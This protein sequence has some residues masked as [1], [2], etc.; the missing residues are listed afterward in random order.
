M[1]KIELKRKKLDA[2]DRLIISLDVSSKSEVIRLCREIDNKV[3]I[4]KLG[5]ELIY[6][7]G[8]DI[9]S[10]VKS[11]GYGVLLDAKL[12]DIPNTVC[13]A[14][15]AIGKLGVE[16]ITI[17]TLGGSGMLKNAREKICKL[18]ISSGMFPPMLLGV[19]ILTSL[20]DMDLKNLGFK[21]GYKASVLNL[22]EVALNSNLDGIICSPNE[23]KL[24][25]K[26]YGSNFFIAT[27]GIRLSEDS[28]ADQKRFSTPDKAISDGADFIIVGRSITGKDNISEA[29]DV[30]LEKIKKVSKNDKSSGASQR[31]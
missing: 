20:D 31:S 9:I 11:F 12:H 4:L 19:T 26:T 25:R 8:L 17:H 1:G 6:S 14:A 18:S 29:I 15:A 23:V 28:P 7:A 22:V 13:K 27:P 16:M 5:L 10:T 30:F 24:I 21:N 2:S 3:R